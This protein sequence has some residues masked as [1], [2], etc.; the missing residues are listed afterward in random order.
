MTYVLLNLNSLRI[1]N[2]SVSPYVDTPLVCEKLDSATHIAQ[3]IIQVKYKDCDAVLCRLNLKEKDLEEASLYEIPNFVMVVPDYNH[4]KG[5][6]L[7]E[8]GIVVV[9]N[10]IKDLE[11]ARRYSNKLYDFAKKQATTR[12]DRELVS[13]KDEIRHL[14]SQLDKIKKILEDK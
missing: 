6:Y 12:E 8:K 10:N 14:K 11:T 7:Y 2:E 9:P 1:I 13:L 4:D 5:R 3:T